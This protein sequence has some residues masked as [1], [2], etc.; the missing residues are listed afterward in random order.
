M[1]N[2][3]DDLG[4]IIAAEIAIPCSCCGVSTAMS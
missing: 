4:G 2:Q 3:L 1:A